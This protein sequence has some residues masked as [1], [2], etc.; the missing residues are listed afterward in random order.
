M[1]QA[2]RNHVQHLK[3]Q[4]A[5]RIRPAKLQNTVLDAAGTLIMQIFAFCV[6]ALFISYTF[7][8]SC[9]LILS[10]ERLHR[11]RAASS[12]VCMSSPCL[13]CLPV[14]PFCLRGKLADRGSLLIE[15]RAR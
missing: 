10:S 14:S 8:T 5:P 2:Q 3:S 12:I 15:G 1:G 6:C 11:N 9:F 13:S 7:T 4:L